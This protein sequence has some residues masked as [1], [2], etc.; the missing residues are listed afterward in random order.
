MKAVYLLCNLSKQAHHQACRRLARQ[1]DKEVIYVRLMEQAREIH[2]GMGLRTMYD[3]LEPEGIGRD[4]FIVLGL[5]EGF[6]LKAIEKQTRT[7]Y[8]VKYNRYRNLL[9]GKR[10]TDVNQVWSSDI[11]YLFCLNRFYY[12]SMIMDIYSRRIVGYAISD[13][14]R[15]ENN[16]QALKMAL[17]LRGITDYR[18]SLIH[19][20]DKGAQYVSDIYTET[21]QDFGAQISMCEDVY[22]NTHIERLNDTIK[23]QYLNRMDISSEKDLNQKVAKTMETYNTLRPHKSLAGLTPVQYETNIKSIPLKDRKKMEIYTVMKEVEPRDPS[24]LNILF[25]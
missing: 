2:P 1:L 9:V 12:L 7:T 5:R 16:L 10:F 11:T 17:S 8:S 13:N 15:A 21:L 23:N 24:Q 4:A 19:H 14:M 18:S 6:R 20:S 3:M 25:N 22:E